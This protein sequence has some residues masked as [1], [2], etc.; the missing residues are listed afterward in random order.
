MRGHRLERYPFPIAHTAQAYEHAEGAERLQ[1]LGVLAET[2]AA[3][4]GVL[5]LGWC[6]T[7]EVRPG[8]VRNW[9]E[10]LAKG[11]IALGIWDGALRATAKEMAEIRDD[12]LT[13]A[14]LKA[15]TGA[16]PALSEYMPVRNRYAHGGWPQERDDQAIDEDR[17]HGG[18]SLLLDALAPLQ[19]ID[20][21]RVRQTRAD[22]RHGPATEVEQL[23]GLP[24]FRTR[25]LRLATELE[26]GTMLAHHGVRSVI[27]LT[28]YAAWLRCH[29]GRDEP[30]YLHQR[31]K[32]RDLYF[33]FGTGHEL[34]R[35]GDVVKRAHEVPVAL[36]MTAP[37]ATAA[38]ATL[39]WRASWADLAPRSAR[40][41]ARLVDTALATA[42]AAIGWA[43]AGALGAPGWG[44]AA[45]TALPALLY[46]PIA[47]YGGL[48]PGKHLLRIEPISIWTS[49]ALG[50][51]DLLRRAI[52]AAPQVL[53]PPLAI[54]NLAW[55]LWDPARQCWHDRRTH[56]IVIDRRTR[57]GHKG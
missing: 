4:L 13:T 27:D 40:L 35:R 26:P 41:L 39:G 7:H 10:R 51:A 19:E 17:L 31:K 52:F 9:E 36:G 47:T 32:G 53:L 1:R 18:I 8:G 37:S 30:F 56:S 50:R 24:P 44:T 45:A 43:I 22:P 5:A 6:R 29:C 48:S 42:A 23:S 11:G 57:S 55:L 20:L 12:P 33:S 34:A 14:L 15:I 28:P 3:T 49:T 2:I 25:N 46:E 16:L 38:R 54:Y 21:A